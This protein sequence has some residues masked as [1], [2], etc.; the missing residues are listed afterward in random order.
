LEAIIAVN[1]VPGLE[2]TI[3][4]MRRREKDYLLRGDASYIQEVRALAG[5]IRGQIASSAVAGDDQA[6]LVGLLDNYE[7]DFLAL[8]AQNERISTLTLALSQAAEGIEPLSRQHLDQAKRDLA[9]ESV[10]LAAATT[11]QNRINL[12]VVLCAVALGIFFR[13]LL[14]R[15]IVHPVRRMAGLLD[16]LIHESPS[17]RIPAIPGARDEINAM[18]ESLNILADH[19]ANFIKW[20]NAAMSEATALR[21]LHEASGQ[22]ARDAAV[23]ELRQA[24]LVKVQQLNGLRGQLLKQADAIEASALRL[25]AN[26]QTTVIVEANQLAR[27]ALDIRSLL[28][29]TA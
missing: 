22:D 8:V 18:A 10:R 5:Q 1:D 28:E 27:S 13:V 14:T 11:Q 4:Q 23:E 19:R 24:A 21:D 26:K 2:T 15:P 17:D 25:R 29:V 7:H 12:L 20:W 9:A 6:Q 3:L 16:R